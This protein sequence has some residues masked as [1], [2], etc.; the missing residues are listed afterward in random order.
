[1]SRCKRRI[2]RRSMRRRRSVRRARSRGV[3][4]GE[5]EG[6]GKW[7]NRRSEGC[8]RGGSVVSGKRRWHFF[9]YLRR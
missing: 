4:K 9:M 7:K 8:E 1:M 5:A 3:A 6:E 2:R